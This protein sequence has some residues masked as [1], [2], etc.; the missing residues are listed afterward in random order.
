MEG[1]SSLGAEGLGAGRVDVLTD[2]S[3]LP[4]RS[5]LRR[6]MD[7]LTVAFSSD[8]VATS[9][10]PKVAA[11]AAVAVAVVV[12]VEVEFAAAPMGPSGAHEQ[13]N[14]WMIPCRC[15]LEGA[16]SSVTSSTLLPPFC[17]PLAG[18]AGAGAAAGGVGCAPCCVGC[19]RSAVCEL[20]EAVLL[21]GRG[22]K[23]ENLL[24]AGFCDAACF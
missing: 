17:L 14:T 4:E 13:S 9:V 20:R 6:D 3:V 7:G 8:L 11:E 1:A 23:R 2:N 15:C 10:S 24:V 12:A 22:K 16:F 18:S 19:L 5:F 21:R